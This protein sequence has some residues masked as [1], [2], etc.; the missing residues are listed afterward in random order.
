MYETADK[1]EP[2]ES[3]GA[4]PSSESMSQALQLQQSQQAPIL[5]LTAGN[6][7]ASDAAPRQPED[8]TTQISD[9]SK[10][11]AKAQ[12]DTSS[13]GKA[14]RKGDAGKSK[15]TDPRP[16]ASLGHLHRQSSNRQI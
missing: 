8:K 12:A 2:S 14:S 10:S 6:A 1:G 16:R 5:Q 3:V 15:E 4:A 7:A 13:S 9:E 11:K